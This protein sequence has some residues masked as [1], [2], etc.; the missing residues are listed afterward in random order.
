MAE[1]DTRLQKLNDAVARFGEAWARGDVAA[2][3]AML[4]PTYTHTDAFGHLQDR[5][6]WLEYARK[7]AGRA[8]QIAFRDVQTRVFGDVAIVTGIN[9]LQGPGVREAKDRARLTIRFTQLWLFR[10]DRWFREAF[11]ATPCEEK[12]NFE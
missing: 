11:Q 2:L 10:E 7:R 4:S 5:S 3:E 6:A 1:D 8:T 9:D 12:V